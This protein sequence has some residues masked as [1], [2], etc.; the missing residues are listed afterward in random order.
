MNFLVI[1]SGL[2]GVGK[3]TLARQLAAKMGLIYLRVDTIET[4]LKRSKLNIHVAEDAGYE[5]G[6]SIAEENL[7]LGQS[8]VAD[9]VNPIDISRA[10]WENAAQKAGCVCYS[11]EIICSDSEEH[12]RRVKA[13]EADLEGHV[14]PTWVDVK[15]RDYDTWPEDHFQL[16]T[17]GKTPSECL[18]ELISFIES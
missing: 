12:Q 14:L 8:V 3:T 10:L 11:V 18:R 6:T 4:A 15:N 16:D 7:T 17:A 1:I 5:V 2:P 13:R 9:S